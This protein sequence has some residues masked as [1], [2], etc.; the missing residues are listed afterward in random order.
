MPAKNQHPIFARIYPRIARAADARGG[1]EHRRR[2]LSGLTGRVIE[3]GAGNGMN[4]GHYPPTVTEVVAVE[5]EERLRMLAE[6][7]VASVPVRVTG[8]SAEALPGADGEFDAAVASLVL[9]SVADQRAALREIGRVLKPGGELRFYEHVRSPDRV[10]ARLQRMLDATFYPALAGGC[11]CSRDTPAA[12]R[13]AGFAIERL[14][15]APIE[16]EL[17]FPVLP[18][19]IGIARA[20]SSATQPAINRGADDLDH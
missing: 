15:P 12:I 10:R 16:G 4:F 6:R 13:D 19:V 8:A 17:V 14:E 9:C 3:V 2:L 18:H 11:H 20:P 7:A 1:A 5:P